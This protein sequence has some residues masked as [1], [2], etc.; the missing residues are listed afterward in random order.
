MNLELRIGWNG[1][2]F[3]TA[4]MENGG[5]ETGFRLESIEVRIAFG[6]RMLVSGV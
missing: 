4:V 5:R 1:G 2:L 6:M 3:V